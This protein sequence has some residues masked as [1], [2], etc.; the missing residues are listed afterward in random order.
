MTVFASLALF[1][2]AVQAQG[3]SGRVDI[4]GDTSVEIITDRVFNETRN[5]WQLNLPTTWYGEQ[6]CLYH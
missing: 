6:S 1:S 2:L 5:V 3:Q 4:T